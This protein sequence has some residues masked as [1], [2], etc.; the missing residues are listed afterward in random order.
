MRKPNNG[1]LWVRAGL[2]SVARIIEASVS[3]VVRQPADGFRP[4]A[5]LRLRAYLRSL[6]PLY[7]FLSLSQLIP[8]SS[9]PLF[10]KKVGE[11]GSTASRGGD[12]V[13]YRGGGSA[14]PLLKD[15]ATM[16]SLTLFVDARSAVG[17]GP[18]K[19][20]VQ[21]VPCPLPANIFTPKR[22]QCRSRI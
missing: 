19:V 3:M 4:R 11:L 13:R 5:I 20:E 7:C 2:A 18:S 6:I 10:E 21:T 1:A 22:R 14:N 17:E 8:S 9:L 16:L 12:G 15:L